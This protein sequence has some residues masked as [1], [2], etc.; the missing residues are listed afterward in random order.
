MAARKW[1]K[2][3]VGITGVVSFTGFLYA[4][5][6]REPIEQ[7]DL[8]EPASAPA[9][10]EPTASGIA[11]NDG[12]SLNAGGSAEDWTVKLFLLRQED[13]TAIASLSDEQLTEREML[14]ERLSWETDPGAEVTLPPSPAAVKQAEPITKPKPK[15]VRKTRRS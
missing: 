10:N 12:S 6:T 9:A 15:S 3:A 11:G 13:V 1:P 7:P 2:W 4:A 8:I 5:Q 14:L